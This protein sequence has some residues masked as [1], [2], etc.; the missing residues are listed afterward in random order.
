M[1][2]LRVF[3]SYAHIDRGIVENLDEHLREMGFDPVWDRDI[4]AGDRFDDAIRRQIARAHLF[5]PLIT[6]NSRESHWVHQEIG[7]ALGINVPVIPVSLGTLPGEMLSTI[8]AIRVEDDLSSL[9]AGLEHANVEALVLAGAMHEDLERLGITTYVADFSEDRT[10]LLVEY[11]GE[12]SGP[13][14]V[15]QRAIFSSFSLPCVQPNDRLWDSI[16][17]P[18]KRSGHFRNLLSNERRMLGKNAQEHGCSLLLSPFVDFEPVGAEVHRS[19]LLMLRNFLVS[20]PEDKVTVAFVE[21]AFRG[22]LT[23]V[24][25][26]FGAKALPSQP[27]FEYRQTIFS[28][29]AP[30]V[31]HWISEFDQEIQAS[32]RS[33]GIEA[34]DSRD[35]AVRRIENRMTELQWK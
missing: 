4:R 30:T 5:M 6:V 1:H 27:G 23:I 26:W 12:I 18:A 13:A 35:Y 34:L 28:H 11:G 10:R 25:D 31:L 19:Q 7:Y 17:L 9:Q 33:A 8:Q 20:L 24:G 2:R 3:I 22:S 15:R 32:L 29:H 16:D 14:H 21:G